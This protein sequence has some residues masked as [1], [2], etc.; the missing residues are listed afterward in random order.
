DAW[1]KLAS[2]RNDAP[3]YVDLRFAN[4]FAVRWA[5][6]APAQ[7]AI[8]NRQSGVERAGFALLG[9]LAPFPIP[10]FRFAALDT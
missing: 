6:A 8:G 9:P 3:A 7:P 2:G 4:G 5:G 10:H 1:P